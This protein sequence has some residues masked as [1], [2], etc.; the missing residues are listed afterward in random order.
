M[1]GSL[2]EL[3]RYIVNPSH[4]L[5]VYVTDFGLLREH[6]HNAIRVSLLLQLLV[7]IELIGLLTE[8]G[9]HEFCVRLLREL[10]VDVFSVCFPCEHCFEVVM[11]G[12]LRELGRNVVNPSHELD[13]YVTNFGLLRELELHVA[14]VKLLRNVCLLRKLCIN[15]LSIGLLRELGVHVGTIR[16]PR[17]HSLKVV[18]ARLFGKLGAEM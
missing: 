9:S 5:G 2:R 4:E 13:V 16:L 12:S 3:G 8:L 15:I 14:R 10:G 6:S 7:D 18:T 17:K 11:A 1:A